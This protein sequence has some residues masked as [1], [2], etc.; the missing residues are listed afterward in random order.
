MTR[1]EA[2]AR[3]RPCESDLRLRGITALYLFGSVARGDNRPESDI[4]LACDIE[5]D[6]PVGLFAFS[7]IQSLLEQ[8]IQATIDLVPRRSLRPRI[9]PFVEA[10][11]IK[12]F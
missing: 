3:L 2:L 10:D 5:E 11:M 1:D 4:D 9:R 12:V 6:Y 8:R 7:G